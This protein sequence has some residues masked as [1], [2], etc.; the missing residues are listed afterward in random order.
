MYHQ[1]CYLTRP[2]HPHAQLI[3]LR[4]DT[5]VN[6]PKVEE[7]DVFRLH[8][9]VHKFTGEIGSLCFVVRRPG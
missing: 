5:D 2:T 1:T 9:V 6:E 7:V 3:K 8:E 4:I